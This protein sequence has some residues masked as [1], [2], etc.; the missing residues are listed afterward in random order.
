MGE[1]GEWDTEIDTDRMSSKVDSLS[2]I[3]GPSDHDDSNTAQGADCMSSSSRDSN[4]VK[5]GTPS[6]SAAAVRVENFEDIFGDN[7]EGVASKPSNSANPGEQAPSPSTETNPS[8]ETAA[9]TSSPDFDHIFGDTSSSA[10]AAEVAVAAV[11]KVQGGAD[12]STATESSG[13]GGGTGPADGGESSAAP[14]GQLTTKDSAETQEFLDFLYD[15]KKNAPRETGGVNAGA[16]AV[17]SN[18]HPED[19]CFS[20]SA[21]TPAASTDNSSHPVPSTSAAQ[22]VPELEVVSLGSPDQASTNHKSSAMERGGG[23]DQS[24]SMS[25]TR[26]GGRTDGA[27]TSSDTAAALAQQQQHHQHHHRRERA[28]PPPRPLPADPAEAL[29]KIIISVPEAS[30]SEGL[31]E[32]AAE[33]MDDV[34]YLRRLCAAT[35]G[36]LAPDLRPAVWGLLLGVG[37]KPDDGGFRKWRDCNRGGGAGGGGDTTAD[38]TVGSGSL[39]GV[40]PP[41][42]NACAMAVPNKL[43]LRNDSL[44]LARRLCAA[45]DSGSG[46]DGNVASDGGDGGGGLAQADPEALAT[47]IEDVRASRDTV[48]EVVRR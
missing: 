38:G 15:G 21:T 1:G 9:T 20:S 28:V 44:A 6:G 36:V 4:T 24:T 33:E 45:G 41:A 16:T 7:S 25:T 10:P 46:S 42:P 22:P 12:E 43:D 5:A 48:L 23:E 13:G 30:A 37:R 26:E 8:T 29:R 35:G 11:S 2:E 17:A 34:G 40:V 14:G 18:D 31:G 47:D 27:C 39:A 19:P 3:F 32:S